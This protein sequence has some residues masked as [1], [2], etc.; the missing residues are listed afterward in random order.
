M[1]E[2][3]AAVCTLCMEHPVETGLEARSYFNGAICK[4]CRETM[5]AGERES[6]RVM[7]GAPLHDQIVRGVA[8]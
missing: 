5:Q 6:G 7:L 8:L 1:D 2:Q 4:P 3:Y